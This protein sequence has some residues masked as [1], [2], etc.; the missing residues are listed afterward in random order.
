MPKAPRLPLSTLPTFRAVARSPNL[1]AAAEQL[2]LTHSAVSQQLKLLESQLGFELFDRRAK[3][4]A[5]N[6]AGAALLRAADAALDRLAEGVL[7]AEAAASGVTQSVR[8]TLLPSFA[9]RWLLP[10]MNRWRERHPGITLELHTS[11][12]LV[13]L[14][15]AGFHAAL[16]HGNGDWRGLHAERL[17]DSPLIAVAAPARAARLDGASAAALAAEPL[18]GTA[19]MWHRWLALIGHTH[20]V[21]PV[22][23]FADGGLMMQ[24]T[25]QDIGIALVSELLAADALIDGRLKRL[26][27]PT[28]SDDAA[29]YWWVCPPE[30]RAWPPVAALHDWLFEEIAASRRELH[31]RA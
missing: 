11:R 20:S 19:E 25:E 22:A 13:D 18:L 4:L 31:A 5:L 8:L 30:L 2:H 6:P 15:R 3:R 27:G 28:L 10:R 9:Q 29:V 12:E 24:A 14:Q 23:T 16:R 17:S 21:R 7:D 26:H 1:R